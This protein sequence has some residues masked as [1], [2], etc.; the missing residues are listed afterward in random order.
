VAFS[1]FIGIVTYDREAMPSDILD[2]SDAST[3]LSGAAFS[4]T[5]SARLFNRA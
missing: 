4:L 3:R 1:V 5:F 2:R